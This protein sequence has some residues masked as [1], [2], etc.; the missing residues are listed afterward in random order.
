MKS[1]IPTFLILL[2]NLLQ[3]SHAIPEQ[4]K[5]PLKVQDRSLVRIFKTMFTNTVI[6]ISGNSECGPNAKT[7]TLTW[8][9]RSSSCFEEYVRN[10]ANV[11][12]NYLVHPEM[13]IGDSKGFYKKYTSQPFECGGDF[14]LIDHV[15]DSWK[16]F[17][18]MKLE[19]QSE[20]SN[21]N[22]RKY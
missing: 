21:S 3:T 7:F 16:P 20:N 22:P 4:G 11:T 5:F 10:I 18:N 13:P 12:E 8:V 19:S 14:E 2:L 9:V 15:D 6:R 1:I 17:E